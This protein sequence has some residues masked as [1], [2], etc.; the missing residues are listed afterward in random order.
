MK[1]IRLGKRFQK[2]VL[3]LLLPSFALVTGPVQ[4]NP[5]GGRVV[6]GAADIVNV[7]ANHLKINQQTQRAVINWD[8]F[9]I[10][11]NELTQFAQPNRNASVLNRVTT[12]NVSH[13]HGQLKGNGNVYVINPNGIFVHSGGVIDVG[14]SAVLSTLDIDDDDFM[15][16]GDD[17]FYGGS[18]AGIT[19]FGSISSG[20]GDV[21]LMGGF[22][23]NSG[24]IGALNGTVAIGAGGEIL[25]KET[26][27]SKISIRSASGSSGNSD[28]TGIS[29]TGT[30]S[31]ANAELKAHGNIYALAINN[32]G[33][34]RATGAT[35]SDGRVRLMSSGSG[36]SSNI[37]LGS[38]SQIVA[39][40]SSSGGSVVVSSGG[41]DVTVGGAIDASGNIDGGSV[42]VTGRNVTQLTG[43]KIDAS[44]GSAG[45]A[46]EVDASEMTSIDGTLDASSPYGAGGSVDVTGSLIVAEANTKISADGM[47]GGKIRV[48]GDFQG[49]DTGLREAVQVGVAEGAELSA[50][51]TMGDAGTV[52]VWA[53]NDTIFLGDISAEARGMVGNGGMIEVSGKQHLIFDGGVSAIS[54]NGSS[55]TVLFDPGD[56]IVGAAGPVGSLTSP[57]TDS[58]I[59]V[60][61]VN[62]TLQ[63]GTDV[64]IV[65]DSGDIYFETLGQGGFD[66]DGNLLTERNIAIQ[67]TNSNASFGA[68]A[69]GSIIVENHIRTSGAGSINLLAGWS[70]A[71]GDAE[72]LFGPQGAWDSYVGSGSFGEGG[73]SI[74]IGHQNMT[75][76]VIVGSRFGDTNVAGFDVRVTGSDTNSASRFSMIGFHDTGQIF[77]PRHNGGNGVSL[78][79]TDTNGDWYLSDGVNGMG[80]AIAG[81]NDPIVGIVGQYE[82]DKNGDGIMDGVYGINSSGVLTDTFIPYANHYNSTAGGNW[83]WQQIEDSGSS[84]TKDPAGLGGLRP[85]NGAGSASN[86]ADINVLARG[87][88][89]IQGGEGREETGAMIGHGGVNRNNWGGAGTSQRDI[90]EEN[91]VNSDDD[92]FSITTDPNNMNQIIE[93]NQIE[94]R[95]TINGST[96]DRNST[97][98]ARLAPVYGNINVLAGVDTSVGVLVNHTAGTVNGVVGQGGQVALQAAQDFETSNQSHNS[99]VQIGHGGV[100]QF[101][102]FYGDIYVEAGGSISLEAG[103]G[104]RSYATIGHTYGGHAYWNPTS[105]EDQQ[106]RFFATAGDFDN[107]NLRRGELFS[108]NVTTGFDPTLDPAAGSRFNLTN[109]PVEVDPDGNPGSGDEYLV[110][111]YTR[112]QAGPGGT[113]QQGSGGL[114]PLDLSPVGPIEVEALDGSTISG[115]HGNIDVISRS[116]DI[117]VEAYSSPDDPAVAQARDRRFAGIGH[118][119]SNFAFWTEGSGYQNIQGTPDTP[120]GGSPADLDGREIVV[121]EIGDTNTASRTEIGNTGRAERPRSLQLMTITGD[122]NVSADDGDIDIIAGNDVHDYARIG[123]GGSELTDPETSSFVLGDIQVTAGGDISL[124]G[125]GITENEGRTGNNRNFDMLAYAQ[126]GHAGYRSGFYGYVGDIDVNADGDITLTGGSHT[127]TYAKIGHQG[128]EDYGQSGGDFI[129]SEEFVR[130]GIRVTI[131]TTL[132]DGVASV[133]YEFYDFNGNLEKTV[134]RDFSGSAGTSLGARNTADINVHAGGSVTLQHAALGKRSNDANSAAMTVNRDS[135]SEGARTRNSFVMIGHGGRVVDAVNEYNVNANYGDKIGDITVVAETGDITM[136]NGS[137]EARWTRIGH[138]VGRNDRVNGTLTTHS[139]AVELAG[140]ITVSAGGKI[141]VDASAADANERIENTDALFGSAAPS[142]W[143][144]VIIGH[145]G[146]NNNLDIVV[147]SAGEDVN[148]IQASSNIAV[149]AAGDLDVLGGQGTE[150]S[151]AQIGHGFSS[152][153]GNDASRRLNVY[154]GFNGDISV[155]V[156]GSINLV[157]GSNA[158]SETPS[159]LSDGVPDTVSGAFAVIG[160]GGYLID[161]PSTGD[162]SIYA[163]KDINLTAQQRTD[164]AVDGSLTGGGIYQ[165]VNP[166]TGYIAS[167][168]NFAKIGH[169]SIE[170]ESRNTGSGDGVQNASQSGDITV[171][172]NRDLNLQAGTTPDVDTQTIYGA[173]TQIGHGGPGISGDVAG[174]VTVLVKRN[175]TVNTGSEI[176]GTT[177]TTRS[178]NNFAM[179]GNGD[180]IKDPVNSPAALFRQEAQGVRS[181]NVIVATGATANFN[182]ALIGHADDAVSSQ[183]VIGNTQVAVSR[184]NPFYGGTGKLIATNGTVFT[185]GGYG[186]GGQLEFY[187]PSRGNNQMDDTTRLNEVSA[188]YTVEPADFVGVSTGIY[189]GREDEVYLT[190]DLWWDEA[191]K[192]ATAGFVGAGLFPSDAVSGQGGAVATVNSPGGLFNLATLVAGALGSSAPAYRDNNGVSGAGQYTIYY[193]ATEFVS[194]TLPL[195]PGSPPPPPVPPIVF[196][197]DGLA[198]LQQYDA[199]ELNDPILQDG[200]VGGDDFLYFGL[201]TFELDESL[202]EESG[203]WGIENSLDNMFG[204]RRDSFSPEEQDE[205]ERRRRRRVEQGVGPI[206]STYYVYDPGTNRYSSYRIFGN[207]TTNFYLTN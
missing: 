64:L 5:R 114:A 56:V 158:W 165:Q 65:T 109:Y 147:L 156:L 49:Q 78:D 140:D 72:L 68:F 81:V 199:F 28:G 42:S 50:N 202:Q 203:A 99:F 182:G 169:F 122:I 37:N 118:G 20:D 70:G 12:G 85:E 94:R 190:P 152:D 128:F 71:E 160:N 143:N 166:D 132:N 125:G 127:A 161:A 4:A 51:S 34:I 189:A 170:D 67:W 175:T 41:G 19:N 171:V 124:T 74:F 117:L 192:A 173:F 55:G 62:T 148:G 107:P 206:G 75:R 168:F 184:L 46:I 185:S 61:S 139:S 149:S 194:N 82:V 136:T 86:G 115:L 6:R 163:G 162:I 191:G 146:I 39:K 204:D 22:V 183:T 2:W 38:N 167:V 135:Q 178:L 142:R 25:V 198:F 17:L 103:N 196:N 57:V 153:Q 101:G 10:G 14:G 59:S 134:P 60:E 106:I 113:H 1:T 16:G 58:L 195:P 11:A 133:D 157:G 30:I 155:N 92:I 24:Q 3:S 35:R 141:S 48:G 88:V 9:S 120:S 96:Q 43:S 108:G 105:V 45:G 13:I 138:G 52:I 144:P 21:I 29:N 76:H 188:A 193:D 172:V 179:I 110:T 31:G 197:F 186:N 123:H 18:S 8:N 100:G 73:G 15:N 129:R 87:N 77:A 80:M 89:L 36:S 137:G 119:G 40:A 130:D 33:M 181:G 32:G 95:W 79:L 69:S 126:I 63:G 26:G 111:A 112:G 164:D 90:S 159:G 66:N 116:G 200:Y 44:G 121:W 53:N 176:D 180:Y 145:G 174:N 104:T 93:R 54:E 97:A 187:I 150:N 205:E 207:L 177:M 98:I 154:T 84:E 23:D 201:G 91:V 7:S 27:Q 131:D 47:V 151:Y 102:E 83:W